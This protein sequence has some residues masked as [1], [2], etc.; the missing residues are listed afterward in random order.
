M[1]MTI[2][3]ITPFPQLVKAVLGESIL[4][5]AEEKQLVSYNI[6]DL[7][8]FGEGKYRQIDDYP[9]GGGTGM[10]MMP[11]PLIKAM[12][13]VSEQIGNEEKRVIFP[14]PQGKKY[15]QDVARE[16]SQCE[17]LVFICGHY[18]G[19]DERVIETHVTDEYSIGD[20]VVTG[21][22]IPAMVIMDSIVRLIPGV[23]GD[24]ES[25]RTDSFFHKL[26]DHPHYT[27]PKVVQG[28]EVPD[29]LL[30]GHHAKIDEW[31]QAQREERTRE[32]RPDIW[33]KYNKEKIEMENEL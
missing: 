13:W 18:K 30:S 33:E 29:V 31:R 23:L 11:E 32:R 17:Y 24:D 12:D 3:F 26:L 6:V 8:Q 2:Y 16:L 28:M 25:A 21:G 22:E 5:R 9:F 19:V 1:R 20:Y 10:V 27:R 15:T 7:R 14:T 4:R